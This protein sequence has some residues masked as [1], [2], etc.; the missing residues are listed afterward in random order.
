MNAESIANTL[1][2]AK[3]S[4]D[5]WA[6]RCP[7]HDDTHA[8]LTLRDGDHR[9]LVKC[10]K[11]CESQAVIAELK[12]RG[13]WSNGKAGKPQILET[14]RYTDEADALLF[15]VVRFEQKDFRQRVPDGAGGWRWKLGN[16]R[17]VLYRL[18]ALRAADPDALVYVVEGERD[19]HR[20]EREGLIATTSP[21]GAGKWRNEYSES[22]RG[23]RVVILPDNDD[24]GRAHG[25]QVA[26]ALRGIAVEV[27]IVTLSCLPEKGDVSNWLDAGGTVEA[28]REL[29]RA[30]PLIEA[31]T[32]GGDHD[33][34]GTNE[35]AGT[36][37]I[38]DFLAYLPAHRYVFRPTREL[39][40]AASVDARLQPWPVDSAYKPQRPSRY[41]DE[42]AAVEQMTWAPGLGEIIE[43]RVIDAGGWIEHRGCRAFNLYR[44]P[45]IVHGDARK[46]RPWVDHVHSV[47]PE[48]AP[49]LIKW[50][51]HRVQ[52]PGEKIN[53]AI[54]LGGKQG[55]GKDTLIEP[56]K[57]AVG[58]WNVQEASPTALMG[59]FNGFLTSV[60]LRIS[61]ARDLGDLDRYSLYDA[62]KTFT[63]A[64]PDV[65]RVDEKNSR[66]HAVPNVTG[67]IITTNHRADGIY[68]PPDD[69]RHYVA[70]SDRE[71][72]E[73]SEGYWTNIYQ[74]YEVGGTEHVAAYLATLVLSAFDPKAPPPKTAAFWAI[75]DASRA[76]E[77]AEVADVIE[78]MQHPRGLTLADLIIYAAE[79]FKEWLRDRR[80]RRRVGHRL[81]SAG[82]TQVRN[83]DAISGLWVV[84]GKRQ[85]VYA[86]SALPTRDRIA[87]AENMAGA[88][89]Q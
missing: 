60:I 28:L 44:P 69:R 10:H 75:V 31:E 63:A 38:D 76:P 42:H 71:A 5:G 88:R 13:A 72:G 58:P 21:G 17:R 89:V 55:V 16:T 67:L 27:R 81:E 25:E 70:W 41:L 15:E 26:R 37:T 86:H 47:Y 8:S 78:R 40:P 74:W 53:H 79:D 59:R 48:D 39:W 64:P 52:R 49:H 29:V 65:L 57:A 2:G 12:A 61:E 56:V 77:D 20:L 87:A 34:V 83:P 36:L 6:A 62:L 68:L 14:Y 19:V 1:E 22:L 35:R 18:P 11:G 85:V 9:V 7:V 50:L 46:A 23:R 45:T 33:E 4:G 66:E 24:P 43:D 80:N 73:F 30:V 32:A 84:D 54:V 51:A 82:Y 3:R